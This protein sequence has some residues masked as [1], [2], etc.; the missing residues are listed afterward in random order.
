MQMGPISRAKPGDIVGPI[1]CGPPGK[2][3]SG[4]RITVR[5]AGDITVLDFLGRLDADT[6]TDAENLLAELIEQGAAKI[7]V[8]LEML[9]DIGCGGFRFFFLAGK[10]LEDAGGALR[11]YAASGYVR[12]MF[13]AAG[14]STVFDIFPDEAAALR[15]F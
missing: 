2:A 7:A 6:L 11:L 4:M 12:E 8:N 1:E 3:F 13:D 9:N 14:F 10:W 5:T 15:N